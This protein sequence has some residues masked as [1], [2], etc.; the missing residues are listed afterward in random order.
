MRFST[1]ARYGLSDM[2]AGRAGCGAVVELDIIPGLSVLCAGTP[3]PNP[4]ELLARPSFDALRDGLYTRYDIILYDTPP[5]SLGEDAFT[6]AARAGGVLVVAR[7]HTTTVDEMH[8]LGTHLQASG[9]GIAGSV[10]NE[11]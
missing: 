5:F 4:L 9:V 6:V 2:L 11:F 10:L 3:P 1:C 7:R 8:A